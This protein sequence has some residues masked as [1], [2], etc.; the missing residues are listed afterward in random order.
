[1]VGLTPN[2][3]V[4]KMYSYSFARG[5]AIYFHFCTKIN[6]AYFQNGVA[7]GVLTLKGLLTLTENEIETLS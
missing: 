5:I 4:E 2:R 3:N 7:N 1:M 6:R